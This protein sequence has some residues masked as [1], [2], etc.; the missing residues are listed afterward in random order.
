M[1]DDTAFDT[2]NMPKGFSQKTITV[3][4]LKRTYIVHA[5]AKADAKKP[6]PIVLVLHGAQGTAQGMEFMSHFSATSDKHGYLVVM[7]QGIDGRW[8]DTRSFTNAD[9]YAFLMKAIADEGKLW[10]IDKS[11]MYISGM[12][13]GGFLSQVLAAKKPGVFAAVGSVA[14]LVLSSTPKP[15][16]PVPIIFFQGTAD[17]IN[18]FAG[19]AIGVGKLSVGTTMPNEE[20]MKFWAAANKCSLKPVE[21]KLPKAVKDSTSVTRRDYKPGPGGADLVEYVVSGGGHTWPG[22]TQFAPGLL[23]GV[24][25]KQINANEIMLDF[26]DKHKLSK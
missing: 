26:F 4:G 23:I 17:P 18:K 14:A 13:N 10:N 2:T 3:K 19:G 1:D 15:L 7:P 6:M 8:S 16:K 12:S 25:S 20:S 22:G 9:E 5:P 21:T 11:R 24:V